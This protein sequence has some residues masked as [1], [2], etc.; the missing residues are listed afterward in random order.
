MPTHTKYTI[1]VRSPLWGQFVSRAAELHPGTNC[2]NPIDDAAEVAL[3][4]FIQLDRDEA[5]ERLKWIESHRAEPENTPSQGERRMDESNADHDGL[6]D[7]IMKVL[8]RHLKWMQKTVTALLLRREAIDA[9]VHHFCLMPQAEA[10]KMMR[11]A[12]G[13]HL[14]PGWHETTK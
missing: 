3:T 4:C 1:W 9:A 6:S 12:H 14:D 13:R 11:S 8:N 2:G 5:I 10:L 7:D